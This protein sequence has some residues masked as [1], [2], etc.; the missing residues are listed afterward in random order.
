MKLLII[1]LNFIISS[2]QFSH[3]A[4]TLEEWNCRSIFLWHPQPINEDLSMEVRP[5]LQSACCK[6]L[7]Q[8]RIRTASRRTIRLIPTPARK[9]IIPL[10]L[11]VQTITQHHPRH[12]RL[13]SCHLR[14]LLLFPPSTQRTTILRG[15]IICPLSTPDW[16]RINQKSVRKSSCQLFLL[17]CN[18]RRISKSLD[19]PQPKKQSGLAWIAEIVCP[20]VISCSN[21]FSDYSYSSGIS[22]SVEAR[23]HFL[24]PA[25]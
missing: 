3:G 6:S 11:Q 25:F 8:K 19:K 12:Q 13:T 15:N 5:Q 7:L 14:K 9:Q 21:H 17:L 16:L 2:K 24:F 1:P 23:A 22:S 18:Q 4:G 20:W 10:N